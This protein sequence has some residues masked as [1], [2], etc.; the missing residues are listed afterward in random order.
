MRFLNFYVVW[1]IIVWYHN[2]SNLMLHIH[3]ICHT[4]HF[5]TR[6]HTYIHIY[7]HCHS[8]VHSS[9]LAPL[10]WLALRHSCVSGSVE[11]ET[12]SGVCVRCLV[13]MIHV[14]IIHVY[15]HNHTLQHSTN[16][17]LLVTYIHLL[18]SVTHTHF[19]STT[20]CMDLNCKNKG[21]AKDSIVPKDIN[22]H[23]TIAYVCV[24]AYR[25][26]QWQ[27]FLSRQSASSRWGR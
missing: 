16:Q 27:R 8:V 23:V 7:V 19:S 22:I 24:C 20:V 25:E 17:L 1:L 13:K 4:G 21:T 5:C 6:I 18:Q 14:I 12:H 9:T 2:S 26:Q 15:T 3:Y 11:H 10:C